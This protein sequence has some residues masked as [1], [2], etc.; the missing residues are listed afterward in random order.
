METLRGFQAGIN[1]GGWLSQYRDFDHE[2]FKTFITADDIGQIA[3]WGLDHVRL[4][5]DYPVIEDDD[6]PGVYKESGFEYIDRCLEWCQAVGLDVVLD[7]HRAPGYFFHDMEGNT[8]FA[9]DAL[10]QRL[11]NLWQA[12]ARRYGN[13][14]SRPRVVFEFLNEI[15]LPSS[16]PWNALVP[17]LIQ[18]VREVTT[19]NWLIVGG[20]QWNSVGT[21]KEL[22]DFDDPRLIYT[23]HCYEPLVFTHQ[24][25]YWVP[26]LAEFGGTFEYPGDCSPEF[27]A[28]LDGKSEAELGPV[29]FVDVHM[30]RDFLRNELQPAIDFMSTH[31]NPLYC[32]EFGVIELA[33]MDSSIRWHRD[34]VELLNELSIGRAHWSYKQMDFGLVD[35]NSKVINEELVRLV[36][37]R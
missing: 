33:P 24:K 14:S 28:Y 17:R 20:N 36:A 5:V 3:S 13:R 26:Q 31:D 16:E 18:A 35:A 11:L 23:F 6:A 22:D 15:V 29:R 8:L 7:L 1:L 12:I 32:G 9:D 25:A 4:P 27:K 34:F 2:H 10:Q 21:L 19:E 37:L 30:D